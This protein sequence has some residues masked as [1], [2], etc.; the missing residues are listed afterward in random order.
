MQRVIIIGAG[1]AGLTAGC[2]TRERQKTHYF[3]KGK[4]VEVEGDII[5][6]INKHQLVNPESN[7][8]FGEGGARTYSDE[9]YIR[10]KK[11]DQ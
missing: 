4:D 1:P 3:Q 2:F 9:E 5:A 8:C 6:A 11:E 10:S 7:Y